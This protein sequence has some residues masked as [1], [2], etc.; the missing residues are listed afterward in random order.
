MGG[1]YEGGVM[2]A[3]KTKGFV[4]TDRRSAKKYERFQKATAQLA[5]VRRAIQETNAIDP[6][7]LQPYTD[8][9]VVAHLNKSARFAHVP[10]LGKY[11]GPIGDF[12]TESWVDSLPVRVL[13]LDKD[14]SGAL[15]GGFE[16]FQSVVSLSHH[17][18][19]EPSGD[20]RIQYSNRFRGDIFRDEW[21]G[22][23]VLTDPQPEALSELVI[24]AQL[25]H[26][27]VMS[28]L[29]RRAPNQ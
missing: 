20:L 26:R 11:I 27:Y 17:T 29:P 7:K 1:S 25:A 19:V 14:E 2:Q 18:F 8:H 5:V 10:E 24:G 15:S 13:K 12:L 16:I 9:Q 6:N 28:Q 22:E 21:F 4:V 23:D 3:E